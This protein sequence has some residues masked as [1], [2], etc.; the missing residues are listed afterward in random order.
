MRKPTYMQPRHYR[1]FNKN[2]FHIEGVSRKTKKF[3][4]KAISEGYLPTAEE[5]R[6][7]NLPDCRW[8]NGSGTYREHPSD[9]GYGCSDCAGTGKVGWKYAKDNRK[10]SIETGKTVVEY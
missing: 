1:Y 8:C 7:S 5:L 6:W 3:L 4:Q 9:S 2:R 10:I